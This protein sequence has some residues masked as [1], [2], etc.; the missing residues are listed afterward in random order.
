M[1]ANI[2]LNQVIK[3]ILLNEEI[4]WYTYGMGIP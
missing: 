4:L 3:N 2:P 1:S